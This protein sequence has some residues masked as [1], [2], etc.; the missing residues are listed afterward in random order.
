LGDF[1]TKVKIKSIPQIQ[2]TTSGES[3]LVSTKIIR[4]RLAVI[5]KNKSVGP[6]GISG[7][8]LKLGG[9]AMIPYLGRLLDVTVNNAAIP[10]D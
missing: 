6:D 2:H 5:G 3:F 9:E 7:K 10:S 4:K 8:I 1:D